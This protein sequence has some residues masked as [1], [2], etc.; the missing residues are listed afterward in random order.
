MKGVGI[1]AVLAIVA[2]IALWLF[3]RGE[4]EA[5]VASAP[6]AHAAQIEQAG[7]PDLVAAG[8]P[9]PVER[10]AA[11]IT[12]ADA[13]GNTATEVV[14]A[15]ESDPRYHVSLRVV[16]VELDGTERFDADGELL[17]DYL[18]FFEEE[19]DV[20]EW[21]EG[22]MP[23]RG[24]QARWESGGTIA[25]ATL[26]FGRAEGREARL[27]EPLPDLQAALEAGGT[28]ELRL[29]VEPEHWLEVRDAAT[30]EHLDGVVLLVGAMPSAGGAD[31]LPLSDWRTREVLR[32]GSSPVRLGA[33]VRDSR[34]ERRLRLFIA[35]RDHAW[36]LVELD[37]DTERHVVELEPG[38]GLCVDLATPSEPFEGVLLL[39]R[40]Q[41]FV[42]L[43]ERACA[44]PQTLVFDHV[45]LGDYRVELRAGGE[46]KRERL[47]GGAAAP[48]A[49]GET[50]TIRI[51]VQPA[52]E[53]VVAE[54][55]LSLVLEL[56]PVWELKRLEVLLVSGEPATAAEPYTWLDVPLSAEDG[57]L[58]GRAQVEGKRP[59]RYRAEFVDLG[60]SADLIVEQSG[61]QTLRLPPPAELRLRCVAEPD[62]GAIDV[63]SVNVGA[64]GAD[65]RCR[66]AV[67]AVRT[68]PGEFRA[69]VAA[70][71]VR[72][73]VRPSALHPGLVEQVELV[74]G[75][76][77]VELELPRPCGVRVT[78]RDQGQPIG[79]PGL[80][81]PSLIAVG[82]ATGNVTGHRDDGAYIYFVGQ[83]GSYWLYLPDLDGYESIEPIEVEILAETV[84]ETV[85][86][87]VRSY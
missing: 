35:A 72:V 12:P 46:S 9:R 10:S 19:E 3:S 7:S 29:Q 18:D 56:D 47:V 76:N 71:P 84:S 53:A 4:V 66:V 57:L 68:A 26:R 11:P 61:E 2:M 17:F 22:S 83:P 14:P 27:V 45:P 60:Y 65:G 64:V 79:F 49:R 38:G 48:V 58:R 5:P 51:D 40:G 1:A 77:A 78:L 28:V 24:G 81:T 21:I 33:A 31:A 87:L 52:A 85:I 16:V 25:D 54:F 80:W 42:R 23:F 34:G 8:A 30:G 59:G 13:S 39:Y 82:G 75:P 37:L 62:G 43:L 50:T 63:P 86:D 36:R 70:G 69:R 55:D 20:A 6:N 32:D 67:E 41:R 74:S 44:V 73:V 15:A